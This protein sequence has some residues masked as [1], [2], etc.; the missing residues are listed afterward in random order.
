MGRWRS[1]RRSKV[2][3]GIGSTCKLVA[4]RIR[5]RG[6]IVSVRI[7]SLR[8]RR[9]VACR[10]WRA[11][12]GSTCPIAVMDGISVFGCEPGCTSNRLE[13]CPA[14]STSAD[15]P[16]IQTCQYF[17]SSMVC[18]GNSYKHMEIKMKKPMIMKA[19]NIHRPQEFHRLG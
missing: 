3:V 19:K 10:A 18:G 9:I 1:W 11:W 16:G 2:G 14:T 13:T 7:L 17:E 6:V 15:G 8:R 4:R 5:G 12:R